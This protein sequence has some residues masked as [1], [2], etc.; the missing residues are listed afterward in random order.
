LG[1]TRKIP[2]DVSGLDSGNVSQLRLKWAFGFPDA[3]RARSAPAI[4]GGA[5]YVGSQPGTVYALDLKSGCV[6]W[7]FEAGTEVRT[8]IVVSP[9]RAGDVSAVP[10]VYFG[11]L[12][13]NIFALDARTGHLVWRDHADEHPSTTITAAPTLYKGRLYVSV[14]SLEEAIIDPTYECCVFRGS[15][16]AYDAVTGSRIW[17]TYLVPKPEFI[18]LNAAGAKRFGPAGAAVWN[19]P[20]IDV[21]RNQLTVGT[22]NDYSTPSAGSDSI[23]AMDLATGKVKWRYQALAHDS[24]NTS[25]Q[26]APHTLCPEEEGPDYDF[27]AATILATASNGQDFV[28]GGAKSG[29]VFAIDPDTGRLIWKTKV[30]RGGILA[31][32]YFGMATSG[33]RVFVPISDLADGRKYKEPAKPGLYALD[34][35]TGKFL[36]K[37]PM[38]AKSCEGRPNCSPGITAAITATSD[39]VMTGAVDGWLRFYDAATGKILW[40]FDTA[41]TFK[42]V[43]GEKATGGSIGGGASPIA[44]HGMVIV[45][46]G[47]GFATQRPGNVLLMFDTNGK[48]ADFKNSDGNH[49]VKPIH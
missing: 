26:V 24:W 47:Y 8:G 29:D 11:D 21:K 3:M 45:P 32:V 6:R 35:K 33:D 18:G 37:A 10:L 44:Y 49:P 36:W 30:G 22:S 4:A 28:L 20:A 41:Q 17:Q 9:W 12:I 48:G 13:G 38:S 42:T 43:G 34:L 27:G 46:S 14:S 15:V 31:G 2:R 5:L 40:T 1:N 25:C 39:L 7:Q 23:V 16:I 19:T